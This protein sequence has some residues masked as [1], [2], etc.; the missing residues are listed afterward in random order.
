M[1]IECLIGHVGVEKFYEEAEEARAEAPKTGFK[2]NLANHYL[3]R[4]DKNNF[5]RIRA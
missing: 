3:D 2:I 4:W 1:D 5:N